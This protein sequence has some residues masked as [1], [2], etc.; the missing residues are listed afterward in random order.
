[1]NKLLLVLTSTFI[2][3][4]T[5]N[6]ISAS[7]V[8]VW[9][10][11]YYTG[12]TFNTG[13]YDFNFSIYDALTGGDICYSN[14]TTLTTG[15]FGEWITEQNGVN[16]ACNNVSKDYYLNININGTDQTPRRRLL[17]WNFLRKDVH[18]VSNGSFET[19]IIKV[20]VGLKDLNQAIWQS[21]L[22]YAE[23]SAN[24]I[25]ISQREYALKV[26]STYKE[27]TNATIGENLELKITRL[28]QVGEQ[29]KELVN[30]NAEIALAK[31]LEAKRLA[32]LNGVT[33]E[34]MTAIEETARLKE[35]ALNLT[36]QEQI[37]IIE[38]AL[39]NS[40][41][42]I[43]NSDDGIRFCLSD[44]T[45][46]MSSSGN[47]F[48][49]VLNTTSD[50]TFNNLTTDYGFF[51]WLG[52]LTSRITKLFVQDID[53]TGN[54]ETSQNV[55]A[56]YFKGDGSLL[57]GINGTPGPQGEKGDT[58]DTG[59]TGSQGI[60]GSQGEVGPQGAA[61]A[62]GPQGPQG[63]PGTS[64][65]ILGSVASVTDLPDT[66]SDGDAYIVDEDGNVYTWG[67]LTS[68]WINIGHIVGPQ[69]PIGPTGQTGSQGEQ[70]IQGVQG[71][72][73]DA[74]SQ[75]IQGE[76][77]DKGDKGDAG[78]NGIDGVDGYTPIYGIDYINGSQGLQGIQGIQGEKGDKGDK[79]D[80]G[81]NGINGIDGINGFNGTFTDILNATEFVNNGSTL[82]SIDLIWFDEFVTAYNYITTW[83]LPD[84]SNG[85]LYNDSSSIYFNESQLNNTITNLISISPLAVNGTN[86]IDGVNGTNGIDGV[87]GTSF[88]VLGN[89]LYDN[90]FNV[91]FFNETKLNGTIDARAAT[92]DLTNYA[93]KNQSETFAG[94]ITATQ[95]G[96][97]GWLGS[98]TSRVTKL[99]VVDIDATGNIETSQNVSANYFKGD[100]SL[101]TNLPSAG[102]ESDPQWSANFTNMK[103]DCPSDN[104]AYGVDDN[105]TLKC[106]QDETG[107]GGGLAPVYLGSNL[108]ATSAG[109]ATI[110][111]IALTPSKMNIIQAYLAQSSSANGVAIQNRV[112]VSEAGP[113]GYCNF[114]TETQ[115]GTEVVDNI[116]VST[117]SADT[118]R[119]IMGLD[120]N[121][122]F[123][124][125][126]TCTVLA[127]ANQKNLIIQFDSET[128]ASVTTY[129]GSYYTNAVN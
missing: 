2:L 9:Q 60:Q 29:A 79:G 32:L 99:W 13:T 5:I 90:G 35:V 129:A 105:G 47:P 3:I 87:N 84:T 110:F 92:S 108:T 77:G 46:C 91:I 55:S 20:R 40:I 128:A 18:E 33:P 114:V 69:G 117:N 101:L 94:N 107:S 88:D 63:E 75:G 52:S 4:L 25:L 56:N 62:T 61:G 24:T 49:Q 83:L 98:L 6:L 71:L 97:F 120:T 65:N 93:L 66:G 127:D 10:G 104:Y 113:V 21:K 42:E 16:S 102:A 73:G 103:T 123:I 96:F 22:D 23:E 95:T 89:Y 26:I 45:N 118:G 111:T 31:M 106:R 74:G 36:A 67:S 17:G 80:A 126:I 41:N 76:K 30:S 58:G 11:Q 124:N 15:G 37:A 19:D 86:G 27:I 48:N 115:A 59:E 82:W 38:S 8:L 39:N 121:V 57:T 12:T 125:K 112:I 85:Y 78:T 44:G 53:A 68:S 100:G 119:T 34:D 70:G 28:Q 54:I 122:L 43:I 64:I 7:D 72:Q 50:V 109:Y 116:A 14:T 1:M 81:T 51:D